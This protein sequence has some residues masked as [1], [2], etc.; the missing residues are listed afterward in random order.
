MKG[1]DKIRKGVSKA[2]ASA[3]TQGGSCLPKDSINKKGCCSSGEIKAKGGVV[4][5][6][7]YGQRELKT[8]PEEAVE[9]S[10]GCGN[11]VAFSR[12]K[13]GEVVVDLGSGAGIDV[14][15]AA[16][17]VGPHGRVIGIDMTEAMLE[18]ARANIEKAGL[19]NAELRYGIIEDMPVED[20]T[21]DW[22]I[23][24]CVVNLS[25][26]KDK[27]FKEIQ[28]I[29]KPGGKML[30]SDIVVEELPSWVRKNES[31]YHSCIAGAISEKEYLEG[32]RKA[33]LTNLRVEDRLFYTGNQLKGLLESELSQ[34][35]GIQEFL[36]S[37]GG[38]T[39]LL[40]SLHSL[41]GKIWSAKIYG[42]K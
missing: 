23:S 18:K 41:E 7:G 40:E 15:L 30:I 13:E 36:N 12:I 24:N 28:R 21:A 39:A 14:L 9:N 35:E 38:Q 22:V 19:K 20:S 27:V 33:G 31:L 26:E 4:A 32:L 37:E 2:Y 11:P 34:I 17:K 16:Q 10:F 25:P 29:L 8:L 6:A 5:A 1:A 42:E 3:L